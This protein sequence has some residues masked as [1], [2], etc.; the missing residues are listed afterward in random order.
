LLESTAIHQHA[1]LYQKDESVLSAI[2]NFSDPEY[3]ERDSINN[4]DL[5]WF[6]VG[7]I[8]YM[9]NIYNMTYQNISWETEA[10]LPVGDVRPSLQGKITI[11]V[12]TKFLIR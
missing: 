2:W 11:I 1:V 10:S 8:P 12:Y 5:T 6:S 9:G 7:S 4:I 3:I